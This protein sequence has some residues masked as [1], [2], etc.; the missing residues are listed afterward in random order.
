[1]PNPNSN[2]NHNSRFWGFLSGKG[3]IVQGKYSDTVQFIIF[4]AAQP[5]SSLKTQSVGVNVRAVIAPTHL[6]CQ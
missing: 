5:I 1:M 4:R 6:L 2:P 3:A